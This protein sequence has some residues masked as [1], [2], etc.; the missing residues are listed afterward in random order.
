M[1]K[2][3]THKLTH[4]HAG[5]KRS[6]QLDQPQ[7]PAA[8]PYYTE[9]R[10][11]ISTQRT[12]LSEW[13]KREGSMESTRSTLE[14]RPKANYSIEDFVIHRTLGTGSFGRVHLAQSRR[15]L[16]FYAIKVLNKEKVVRL[17]QVDH[18]NSEQGILLSISH[19]FIINLW[20]TFQDATNLYMIMDFVHG[21]ELFTL[22]RKAQGGRFPDPVAK[23]YAAE[24]AMALNYLHTHDI[25]YRDL[26]PENIL[27]ADDGHI[28]I[29]D[30]GFAKHCE[31]TTWTLCGTPDYLAPE[32]VNQ[33]RYNK[34]VD[35]Y[36][37]GVLIFEMLFGQPPFHE[38]EISPMALYN[39]ISKGPSTIQ[40]PPFF[41]PRATDLILKLMETDPSKR[42]GNMRNGAGDVF[43][44]P[45]FKEV[46]WQN[47]LTKNIS[48]PYIP[49]TISDGD[50]S[51]FERYPEDECS[52]KYGRPGLDLF[53]HLFEEWD[54]TA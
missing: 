22:L 52:S 34:S 31:G 19:P 41:N 27:L 47:L 21:G 7:L 53:G 18:T 9:H 42:Y 29:A 3:M 26:K 12:S 25:V 44:H 51:A 30:F 17:K 20:G 15:N 1:L 8:L 38:P 6:N 10:A 14:R 2:K 35:W 39:K 36:A 28:K 48:P 54:Y 13:S 16:R 24:V 11:S 46:V 32:V 40:W 37:L 45:W 43:A 23:F 49:K 4:F 33:S 50:A 5:Q